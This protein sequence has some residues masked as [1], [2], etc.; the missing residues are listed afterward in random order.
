MLTL[1]SSSRPAFPPCEHHINATHYK[2]CG[3]SKPTPKC[4]KTLI[5]GKK[6]HGKSVYSV[7]P[8]SIEKEIMTHGPVEA[9]FTVYQDFLVPLPVL[10]ENLMQS[11]R[12]PR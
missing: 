6:Y 10:Y 3:P 12:A 11:P 8:Q 2:P 1:L 7:M 5:K 4:K 9:A